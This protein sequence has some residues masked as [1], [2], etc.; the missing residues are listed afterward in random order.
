MQ[1]SLTAQCLF[2]TESSRTVPQPVGHPWLAAAP[3]QGLGSPVCIPSGTDLTWLSHGLWAWAPLL[4]PQGDLGSL[5]EIENSLAVFCMATYGEGDPT[6]NA[7]DFYDWL[8]ETDVDLS[9]VKYAVSHPIFPAAAF[10]AC[11]ASPGPLDPRVQGGKPPFPPRSDQ[12]GQA[13]V[14]GQGASSWGAWRGGQGKAAP[15][16]APSSGLGPVRRASPHPPRGTGCGR[17]QSRKVEQAGPDS[18]GPG[19]P[20]REGEMPLLRTQALG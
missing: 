3:G 18:A 9:G 13:V 7:Q 12:P 20:G 15:G 6:D 8:Q 19:V 2:L 1:P 17:L 10:P 4:S 5:P 14:S 11:D 16:I